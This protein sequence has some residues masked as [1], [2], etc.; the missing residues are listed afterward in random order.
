MN[1]TNNSVIPITE[2][3]ETPNGLQCI[4]DRRPCCANPLNRH[5]EW[6]F[7]DDGGVVPNQ[8]G[9]T[10]FYRNRGDDGTVNLNR[11][12]SDVM[13]PTG[14]FCCVVPDANSFNQTVCANIG[15]LT[16]TGISL[17]ITNTSIFIYV[18]Y[19]NSVSIATAEATTTT[20]EAT[21][22]TAEATT[23]TIVV[24]T[25]TAVTTTDMPL[26]TTDIPTTIS[27][28]NETTTMSEIVSTG[29]QTPTPGPPS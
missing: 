14:R 17:A 7:P 29:E 4:T 8:I 3:Q 11:L 22:T 24:T 9:A 18:V 19:I 25:V 6:F 15:K 5:G 20:A 2:I 13:M 23:T 10:S 21:T 12:N 27:T 16:T 28:V 1:Y 26:T